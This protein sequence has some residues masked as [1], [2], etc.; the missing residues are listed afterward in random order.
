MFSFTHV[1]TIIEETAGSAETVND[2]ANKLLEHVEKLSN[3][4]SVLDENMEG[5]K[6]ETSVFK[7]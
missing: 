5:L 1:C 2:V 6:N 7:I 3:T 4:A